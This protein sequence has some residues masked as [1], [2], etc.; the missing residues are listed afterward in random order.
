MVRLG[1]GVRGGIRARVRVRVRIR[2]RARPLCAHLLG[3]THAVQ[4]HVAVE[5][6]RL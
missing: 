3:L 5:E 1:L 2:V 6:G 4:L